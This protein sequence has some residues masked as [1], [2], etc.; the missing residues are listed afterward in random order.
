MFN[1][2]DAF[3]L[4][5]ECA[6]RCTAH[7]PPPVVTAAEVEALAADIAARTLRAIPTWSVLV[8]AQLYEE[9]DTLA[10][11]ADRVGLQ[12]I[13]DAAI[14][15]TVYL[16]SLVEAGTQASPT[17][18]EQA[19]Q[20]AEILARSA[21]ARTAAASPSA[22]APASAAASV[23]RAER[24]HRAVL[25]VYP[26]GHE[27]P[28]LAQQLG[29]ERFVVRSLSET[30]RA[31]AEARANPP[32]AL[33]VDVAMVS[34]L[35]TL[36]DTAERATGG[37]RRRPLSLVLNDSGDVRQRLFAQRA[38][39]DAVLE[40]SDAERVVQR[41]TELFVA[42][43]REDARIL[44]VDDDR[45]MAMFCETVLG[46]KGMTT[47]VAHS[48]R[49]A[50]DALQEFK[51]DLVLLDLYMPDMNGIEVAQL[52]RERPDM[53]L[54]PI[55]FMSGE[56]NL[57]KR[58]D[59]IRM[60]GDDFLEKPVKPRHLIASV[61]S[62]VSRARLMASGHAAVASRTPIGSGRLDRATLVHE[63]ERSRRGELGECV[64]LL[65]LA[66]DDV[67]ALARRLGFVRTGDLAQQIISVL[68]LEPA[69][70]AGICALGEFSFLALL[71]VSSPGALRVAG[72]NVRA[73][74]QGRG[75][76]A[77]DAPVKVSF[78]LGIARVDEGNASIDE[79]LAQLSGVVHALQEQGGGRSQQVENVSADTR[80]ETLEQK[81][82]RAILKRQLHS[83]TTRLSFRNLVPMRGQHPGQFLTRLSLV[84]A[85]GNSATY[86]ESEHF[87]PI[88]RELNVIKSLDRWVLHAVANRAAQHIAK[89]G[90]TRL[91]VPLSPESLAEPAFPDWLLAELKV[92]HIDA[93]VLALVLNASE[94]SL[95]V[96]K[97]SR[98]IDDLQSTGARVCL[99]GFSDAGRDQL[100]L[101]R[102]PSTY[103][104]IISM[105]PPA[106]G[107]EG[108]WPDLRRKLIHESLRHG[109][110]VI[111]D[112]VNEP[113]ALG[114]LFRENVHYVI[115]DGVGQW[116]TDMTA[117]DIKLG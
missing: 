49:A 93:D 37:E 23:A 102:L 71:P 50:L 25:Y 103:A 86:I 100:R 53:A 1:T 74:L 14:E 80:H 38:G 61:S 59:A 7:M 33:I 30:N 114:D 26:E 6:S 92:L 78:T 44:I 32:D 106:A 11:S 29:H 62:R 10:S 28:G 68:A 109:K 4:D 42:Q 113:A 27:L 31:L 79:V 98:H 115:G 58:F 63:I 73:R 16:S 52:I 20:L 112:Q 36:L 9:I 55:I 87:M 77:A 72:E 39:A 47:Q 5:L 110:I 17:Q 45:D 85:R 43:R 60:G 51:P 40:G 18:R 19:T 95:D 99:T 24:K 54:V 64:G 35:G 56:E 94:L 96:A 70:K 104:N 107:V 15:L 89:H 117:S 21:G 111:V 12:G 22:P 65:M 97:A 67:P 2:F 105:T 69:F 75:W 13:A 101:A 57:D 108:E 48:A 41:L 46:Y 8:M 84:A 81:L 3:S 83:E 76:L 66:V 116:G 82:S 91:F 34:I 88:A 90:D